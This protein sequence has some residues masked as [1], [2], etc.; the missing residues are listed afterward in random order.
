LIRKKQSYQ[1]QLTK[2]K[3]TIGWIGN[4]NPNGHG[5]N[6]GF[7]LIKYCIQNMNNR[8][9]FNPQDRYKQYIEHD[10]IPEYLK[11]I[12][13]IVCFSMAEGTP[14]Q[15][16]EASSMGKCWIS[17]NVGI[18]SE[19]NNLTNKKCGV[20]IKRN[21]NSLK[22]ALNYLYENR[23]KIVEY[24]MNGRI[25]IEKMWDWKIKSDQFYSFF[26]DVV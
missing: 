23:N 5:I 20:V 22:I 6:K 3:L 19:L 10:L 14:N 9:D 4:S 21:E 25:M 12:D 24:G 15:I 18:V 16:L 17:T 2:Q 1:P 13:I 11:D 7:D 26:D 8:F